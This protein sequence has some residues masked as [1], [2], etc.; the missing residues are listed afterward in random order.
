M[1]TALKLF[2]AA[3]V[4]FSVVSIAKAQI[5][6]P[7]ISTVCE[8]KNGQ[9]AAI[10]DGF[11]LLKKCPDNGRLVTIIGEKGDKGEQGLPGLTGA[12]NIAFVFSYGDHYAVT[13]DR[14]VWNWNGSWHFNF[15]VPID[16]SKI[17]QMVN[18]Y[19]FLDSDGNVWLYNGTFWTNVGHP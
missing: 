3:F 16:T 9:L 7:R 19:G 1:K 18:P 13:T 6:L 10:D 15:E 17:V 11:S 4:I 14:K 2:F 12:G 8:Y 5:E